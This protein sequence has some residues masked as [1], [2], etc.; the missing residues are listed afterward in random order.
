MTARIV[1]DDFDCESAVGLQLRYWIDVFSLESIVVAWTQLGFFPHF[2]T[3][4]DFVPPCVFV[5]WV[6]HVEAGKALLIALQGSV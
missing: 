4:F 1:R 2:L 6:C 5:F 3:V